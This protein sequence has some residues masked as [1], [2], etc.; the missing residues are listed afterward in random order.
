M[1][2]T[3][4]YV[5]FAVLAM[6][7]FPSFSH[8][9]II[10][11]DPGPIGSKFFIKN[12]PF[13]EMDGQ[14]LDGSSVILDFVFT[15]MKQLEIVDT[16]SPSNTGFF[17]V[18]F[19]TNGLTT[20]PAPFPSNVDGFLSDEFGFS[21]LDATSGGGQ[22]STGDQGKATINFNNLS[23]GIVFHDVHI[24]LDL[25]NIPSGQITAARFFFASDDVSLQVGRS[26]GAVP[27]PATLSLLGMGI[28]LLHRRRFT[29]S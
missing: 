18:I 24:V 13:T 4:K 8:A 3:L 9:V 27:E 11:V 20:D 28:L 7:I 23:E 17:R 29:K 21:I 15:D 16:F 5:V 22:A 10:P 2:H 6:S 14:A 1:K 26:T 19:D 25:P 12:I